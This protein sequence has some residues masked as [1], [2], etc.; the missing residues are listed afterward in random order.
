MRFHMKNL[1]EAKE[2]QVLEVAAGT[3]RRASRDLDRSDDSPSVT[4]AVNLK[5]C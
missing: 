3:L 1:S 4:T 5:A 2:G